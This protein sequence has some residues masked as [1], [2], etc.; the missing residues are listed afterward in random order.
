M[1]FMR[2][3][4]P[5]V[6]GLDATEA[7]NALS[8]AG[9]HVTITESDEEGAAPGRVIRTNPEGGTLLIRGSQVEV[10]V[11]QGGEKVA[12]PDVYRKTFA[13]AQTELG[14]QQLVAQEVRSY[15]DSVPA[16]TVIGFLPAAGTRVPAG[17][18]VSVLVSL[19]AVTANVEVPSVMG[20]SEDNARTILEEVGFNP[21][22]YRASTSYG[23]ADEVVAQ[24]PGTGNS[25][26]PGSPVMV[27]I[28]LGASTTDREVPDL[29]NMSKRAADVAI[30]QAGFLPESFLFV[31]P[32]TSQ[33][34][35]VAQMPPVKDT[36]LRTG[37]PMG[38]L[39]SV[40]SQSNA[41]VPN[42][43]AMDPESAAQA[44]QEAG[45]IPVLVP[46]PAGFEDQVGI[47]IQ[48]FPAADNEYHIGLPVLVFVSSDAADNQ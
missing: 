48:Q 30:S 33:G 26:A 34:Q 12:V 40:G 23:S 47:V 1:T 29:S 20:L 17:S 39:L 3:E 28:S 4:V 11:F 13:E 9:F 41:S 22:F 16:G 35:V 14:Q 5:V 8:A 21:V 10:L 2:E 15:D 24:T 32:G 36:L 25:V 38:Y 18:T 7:T 19:G 43:L 31:D 46:R 6:R 44:L 45:F 42:V 27:L 37:E